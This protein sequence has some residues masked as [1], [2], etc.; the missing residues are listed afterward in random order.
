MSVLGA[1]GHLKVG[2]GGR[3]EEQAA[4]ARAQPVV[5]VS[6]GYAPHGL[7]SFNNL[8]NKTTK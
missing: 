2:D 6:P 1:V 5:Q 3:D 7:T 4:V 8:W